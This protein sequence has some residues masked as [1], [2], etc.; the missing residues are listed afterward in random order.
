MLNCTTS[1]NFLSVTSSNLSKA[2]L[3]YSKARDVL[4]TQVLD[5][6]TC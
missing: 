6:L 2:A 1:G 5:I 3:T 4:F